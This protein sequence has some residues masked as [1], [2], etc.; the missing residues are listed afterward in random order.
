VDRLTGIDSDLLK[1]SVVGATTGGEK[2]EFD[3]IYFDNKTVTAADCEITETAWLV[4]PALA[5]TLM[6]KKEPEKVV[7][8][9]DSSKKTITDQDEGIDTYDWSSKPG[10]V[11][12]KEG[13]RRLSRVRIDIKKL[14]WENWHDVYNEVIQPLA[15]EGAEIYCQVI[16]MASGDGAI[17]EN[18]VELG[19]KE[20]LAQRDIKADI[21]TG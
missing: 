16:V 6:P 2:K 18:T 8:E 15:N 20:S 19:I 17:R 5:K 12:I 9:D 13:E 10:K 4:R 3:T 1:K 14:P 21:Q 11:A 7:E